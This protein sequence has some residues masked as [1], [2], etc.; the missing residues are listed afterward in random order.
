MNFPAIVFASFAADPGTVLFMIF[1][2]MLSIAAYFAPSLM[3]REKPQFGSVFALNF[4]L[5]WTVV[6]WVVALA[7]ALNES[8]TVVVAAPTASASQVA[9]MPAAV[10][11]AGC[12]KYSQ[13]GGKFCPS[14]G[15]AL[16]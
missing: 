16:V 11:C 15:A 14:C 5:G 10:F 2:T 6:G 4:F 13:A 12:G 1:M 9:A 3:A 7:W 8:K